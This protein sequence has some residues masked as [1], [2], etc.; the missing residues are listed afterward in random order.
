MEN[1]LEDQQDKDSESNICRV[2]CNCFSPSSG[3]RPGNKQLLLGAPSDPQRSHARAAGLALSSRTAPAAVLG[4]QTPA[5]QRPLS[6]PS[7]GAGRHPSAAVASPESDR[8]RAGSPRAAVTV[9]GR[10]PWGLAAH[11]SPER[12]PGQPGVDQRGFAGCPSGIMG[13]GDTLARIRIP[14][15]GAASRA[16]PGR[17]P[18][19]RSGQS[20]EGC[21][22]SLGDVQSL[23]GTV[24][25]APRGG[26]AAS[27]KQTCV[28]GEE[29][30]MFARAGPA[31]ALF[32]VPRGPEGGLFIRDRL[33]QMG[34]ASLKKKQSSFWGLGAVGGG[35]VKGNCKEG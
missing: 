15:A 34:L 2:K 19:R 28:C 22:S 32:L 26:R 8:D 11:S 23:G 27:G 25:A 13:L 3:A 35:V 21:E 1:P 29:C 7:R 10:W 12:R 6:T 16:G 9:P 31:P 20:P 30:L 14:P 18:E 4:A 24:P 17:A 5:E 33:Y